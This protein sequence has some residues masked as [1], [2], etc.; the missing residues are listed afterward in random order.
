MKS[1][2][3]IQSGVKFISL[4]ASMMVAIVSADSYVSSFTSSNSFTRVDAC[5]DAKS[6]A[7][8]FAGVSKHRVI[9]FSQCGCDE[10]KVDTWICYVDA[11]ISEN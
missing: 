4:L 3:K 8:T 10:V 6:K 9:G 1:I 7:E 11:T 2:N 5:A